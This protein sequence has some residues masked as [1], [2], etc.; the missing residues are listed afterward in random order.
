MKY[1]TLKICVSSPKGG[2][3]KSQISKNLAVLLSQN[4]L[5]PKAG[6]DPITARNTLVDTDPQGTSV[7]F[8]RVRSQE[9]NPK[10]KQLNAISCGTELEIEAGI[11]KAN[12]SFSKFTIIDT[13]PLQRYTGVVMAALRAADLVVIPT[14]VTQE[15]IKELPAHLARVTQLGKPFIVVTTQTMPKTKAYNWGL[16]LITDM[17]DQYENGI[18]CPVT[19]RQLV[20]HVTAG[21]GYRIASELSKSSEASR[22][23]LAITAFV[24]KIA[25]RL[26]SGVTVSSV[27]TE[28]ATV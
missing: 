20:D 23:M 10:I 26:K 18:L 24:S 13:P 11:T 12:N 4:R 14:K 19:M 8:A 6:G 3:S 2:V 22:D 28:L 17:V 15:D 16:E 9:D 1:E 27:K 21:F 7:D 5:K 25:T